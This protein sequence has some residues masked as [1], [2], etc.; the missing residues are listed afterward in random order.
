MTPVETLTELI[1]PR[2]DLERVYADIEFSRRTGQWWRG[3]C[4]LHG[5]D[6]PNFAVN[7]TTLAYYCHS[8]CGGGPVVD[9]VNGGRPA[10]GSDWHAAVAK[11][12]TLAGVEL[13]EDL[14]GGDHEE[15]GDGAR[16]DRILECTVALAR[17][18]LRSPRGAGA[19]EYLRSRLP[20]HVDLQDL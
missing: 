10:R 12:A 9:Y 3:P 19:R 16:T 4:P 1:I 11:L 7:V 14:A 18:L 8:R 20:D 5:G 17:R 13:S 2:L 15:S 6:G